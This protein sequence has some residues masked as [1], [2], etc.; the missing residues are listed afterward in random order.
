MKLRLTSTCTNYTH[1]CN[2]CSL[3]EVEISISGTI[4]VIYLFL[5][6][7][8][9]GFF[10]LTHGPIYKTNVLAS[11]YVEQTFMF[12]VIYNV[13]YYIKKKTSNCSCL[14]SVY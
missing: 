12:N 4:T 5:S 8:F 6:S 13:Y 3:H 11:I 1:I 10:Y 7:M 9:W 14:L 2:I